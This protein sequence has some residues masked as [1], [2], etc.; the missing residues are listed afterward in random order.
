MEIHDI[1]KKTILDFSYQYTPEQLLDIKCRYLADHCNRVLDFGKSSRHRYDFFASG[2]ILTAD[3]NQFEDYPDIICDLCERE[4]LPDEKFDGII[5]NA[6]LEHTYNPIAAA[7]NLH[8]LL[9]DGSHCLAY[10]PFIYRYHSFGNPVVQ[11]FYR[12]S[13]D[14][15]AYLFRLFSEVTLFPVRGRIST[16][17]NMFPW[18]KK[19]I[20]RKYGKYGYKLDKLIDSIKEPRQH[21][22]QV[23]GFFVWAQK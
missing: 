1:I 12:F 8:F 17:L 3:I 20:E 16:L 22:I 14:G 11:D 2:Q 5:C 7:E 9:K 19:N 13:N 23:S 15:L 18:W 6:V 10:A 21:K 4:S